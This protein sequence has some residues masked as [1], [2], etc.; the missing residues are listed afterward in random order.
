MK[1]SSKCLTLFGIFCYTAILG[2]S[3]SRIDS[4]IATLDT[5]SVDTQQVDR[6][7]DI[8]SLYRY[9]QF[10]KANEYAQMAYHFADSIQFES[11]K[12]RSLFQL[13][14][15][16]RKQG[17]EDQLQKTRRSILSVPEHFRSMFKS[18]LDGIS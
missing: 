8:A 13:A 4:L 3:S 6:L 16:Y 14:I 7:I 1:W 17:G 2:Q 10:D 11:G 15:I 18:G 12:S 9:K 5:I